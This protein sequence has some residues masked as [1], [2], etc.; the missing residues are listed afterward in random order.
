MLSKRKHNGNGI[1]YGVHEVEIKCISTR[2]VL[3][4]CS[5]IDTTLKLLRRVFQHYAYTYGSPSSADA[6][7]ME[8]WLAKAYGPVLDRCVWV[9]TARLSYS[10]Y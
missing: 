3:R 6:I 5:P 9:E 7:V 1:Y 8:A 2:C 4:P 10:E